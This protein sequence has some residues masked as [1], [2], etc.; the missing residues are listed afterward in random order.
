MAIVTNNNWM[1]IPVGS[2][3]APKGINP[4]IP[5]KS[6]SVWNGPGKCPSSLNY[7]DLEDEIEDILGQKIKVGDYVMYQTQERQGTKSYTSLAL[8]KQIRTHTMKGNRYK[9]R[10]GDPLA[11]G[12]IVTP[13]FRKYNYGDKKSVK[14]ENSYGILK[15]YL[16]NFTKIPYSMVEDI[17][18]ED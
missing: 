14:V 9:T 2:L 7:E 4:S 11:Y 8:V 3:T 18:K 10:T 17:L 16:R 13:V 15:R 12:V 6:F 5:P 1:A